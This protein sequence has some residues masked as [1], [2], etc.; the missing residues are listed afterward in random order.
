MMFI[1]PRWRVAR[2]KKSALGGVESPHT[3]YWT[4]RG[5]T[6]AA[7]QLNNLHERYGVKGGIFAALQGEAGIHYWVP[8]RDRAL[9]G[10]QSFNV[11][12]ENR[13]ARKLAETI[14]AKIEE[15]VNNPN[16]RVK[17]GRPVRQEFK[18]PVSLC[19]CVGECAGPWYTDGHCIHCGK[20][21]EPL[22]NRE[23]KNDEEAGKR[24]PEPAV[25]TV[26]EASAPVGSGADA[27]QRANGDDGSDVH[28]EAGSSPVRGGH[29]PDRL[30]TRGE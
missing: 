4:K 11:V 27:A 13:S 7:D 20:L 12:Q 22:Q 28:D 17:A 9:R 18:N 24:G 5:A 6:A 16:A 25:P 19:E 2:M 10:L 26:D 8:I 14:N 1:R 23:E 3:L 15:A 30:D 29:K 21:A